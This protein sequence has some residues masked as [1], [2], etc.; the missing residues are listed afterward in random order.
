MSALRP[1][2]VAALWFLFLTP[3]LA[4]PAGAPPTE[5]V[6]PPV[7]QGSTD[8][9][10]P[11]GAEG[12]AAVVLEILVDRDG[13]VAEVTVVEGAEPFAEHARSAARAWTF[14]PARRG[15]V[16]VAAKIRARIEFRRELDA[17]APEPEPSATRPPSAARAAGPHVDEAPQEVVVRGRRREIGQTTLSAAEVRQLPGAFGDAFRAVE[18]MPGV[19]PALSG[20]PYFFVRGAPPNDNGYF[21]DGI[22]V[23]LLFHVGLGPSVIH[24]G[25]LERVDFHSGAAPAS[26]GGFAGG[27]IAGHTRP[28]AAEARGEANVRLVDAGAL[29]E[30]PF[31]D[32]RGSALLAGRYGYPGPIVGALSNTT[33]DYWDYQARLS[34]R[35]TEQGTTSLLAFGSHDYLG[36]RDDSGVTVEDLVSD[37]H[38]LDL[39]HD[40]PWSE[41][42]LRVGAT[43]GY[44]SQGSDPLYL[45]DRSAA[46]RVEVEQQLVPALRLRAGVEGGIDA[47]ALK[48]EAPPDPDDPPVPT[49]VEPP[50]TNL[51]GGLHTDFV[52]RPTE[53]VEL[54]PGARVMLF[55]SSRARVAGDST[56]ARTTVP[57]IEPRFSARITLTRGAA[58]LS[59]FGL[60]HQYP[61]L[62][63]G[64]L[65]IMVA[66]GAGF[67]L[68]S[69][70][71]QRTLHLTQG[72]ELRL[73]A[74]VTLTATGFLA[75]SW[76]LTDL[77]A[78]CIQIEPPSAPLNPGPPPPVPYHCPSDAPVRGHAHGFELLVRRSV[79]ERLS[80]WLSYTLSRS[81]R[82]A[83]FI[84]LDGGEAVATVP[85][86]F[87]R[88][89]VLNAVL[90]YDLG[91]RWHAGTRLVFYSGVP[92]SEL[93]G[94]VPV[95]PYNS[96]RDPPF[97][98]LDV[99][100]EK[101]WQ[102]GR[103]SSI[104][105]VLEGQNVTLSKDANTLGMDCRGDITTDA[106][107]TVCERG[108][109]GPITIPSV[110][111]EAFF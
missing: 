46:L 43:V 65:P 47:Y 111:V 61:V 54:V 33:L 30:S 109:I 2:L 21:L 12:D 108:E 20:L 78:S 31:A 85:S 84:T 6:T 37:F 72:L 73:P 57:A 36:H 59:G 83:R 71:L 48:H 66:A 22:R 99:R 107:T 95:P 42:R 96:R 98:R 90:G 67:P 110:G 70:E 63:A 79:S 56:R 25:L 75:R 60:A 53:R 39:R 68:G 1:W 14:E 16:A 92:Y 102:L 28:S 51:T 24:P 13:K 32:G 103:Q 77:T 41:G 4:R 94:N 76:G 64:A 3:A 82:E 29:L 17:A 9:P 8:V 38:R 93:A 27:I 23:P 86:D 69:S 105:F 100:L 101:R 104:A 81:I 91:R 19:T 11:S 87:D 49:G 18:I 74:Q 55:D 52:W 89:H 5:V 26:Y 58:W 88:T 50:P 34:W 62:R 15:E 80:G 40:E 44:D 7:P 10:Y 106:Y 35:T 97:V 45:R